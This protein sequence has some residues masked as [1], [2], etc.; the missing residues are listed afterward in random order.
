MIDLPNPFAFP[1]TAAAL[2]GQPHAAVVS[3]ASPDEGCASDEA[4]SRQRDRQTVAASL[5]PLSPEAAAVT[6]SESAASLPAQVDRAGTA[7]AAPRLAAPAAFPDTPYI[8]ERFS[9]YARRRSMPIVSPPLPKVERNID[10]LALSAVGAA[11][12]LHPRDLNLD[13]PPL[14]LRKPSPAF[15]RSLFQLAGISR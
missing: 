2:E 14:F 7:G 5:M 1:E 4:S 3:S 10:D 11:L 13:P 9:D 6:N 8:P 12:N 15:L